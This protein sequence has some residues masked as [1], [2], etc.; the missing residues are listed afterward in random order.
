MR[1]EVTRRADLA[2][3]ALV[4]LDVAAGRVKAAELARELDTTQGFVPQVLGPLVERGWVRSDPGPTGGYSLLAD[5]STLAVLD[6]IE[7]VDGPTESGR[8]VVE[9]RP[10]HAEDPC[11]L[12]HAW[13]AARTLLLAELRATPVAALLEPDHPDRS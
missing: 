13:A 8:C 3:R 12:H 1:L 9:D 7:A 11:T 2:A 10:C 6:V 4:V 5:T